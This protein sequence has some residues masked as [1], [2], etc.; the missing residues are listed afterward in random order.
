MAKRTYDTGSIQYLGNDKYKL[1]VRCGR[2]LGGSY[3]QKVKTITAKNDRE[4]ERA[5]KDFVIEVSNRTSGNLSVSDLIDEYTEAHVVDLKP[6]TQKW[7][8]DVFRR[9]R[10]ALGHY[11]LSALK[12]STIQKFYRELVNPDATIFKETKIDPKTGEKKV[13]QLKTGLSSE[14][15]L[16]HHR[17]L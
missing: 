11:K 8:R 16:H 17:A 14:K 12:P 10:I 6:Y 13:I 9:V 3:K 7:Y 2:D 4:A 1:R 15:A 5:L